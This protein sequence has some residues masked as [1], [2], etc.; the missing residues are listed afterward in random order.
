MTIDDEA[1]DTAPSGSDAEDCA[2]V[3][4]AEYWDD[5][6]CVSANSYICEQE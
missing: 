5:E 4:S 2:A 6:D 1:E 3:V